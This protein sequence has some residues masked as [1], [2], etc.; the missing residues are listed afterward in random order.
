MVVAVVRWYGWQI[1]V[2]TLTASEMDV[3]VGRNT[4][5]FTVSCAWTIIKHV[6][7]RNGGRVMTLHLP[8]CRGGRGMTLH[9]PPC[10][11][12]RGMTLHLP[13]GHWGRDCVRRSLAAHHRRKDTPSWG[14]HWG[15]RELLA[16]VHP[17]GVTP[18]TNRVHHRCA[19]APVGIV[20][21]D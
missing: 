7:S 20:C 4:A 6:P 8:P 14:L 21:I 16:F 9:L 13:P 18:N 10:C 11:G 15:G 5:I 19:W 12:G 2:I 1:I 17:K 3:R